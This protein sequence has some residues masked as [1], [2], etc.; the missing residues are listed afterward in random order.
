VVVF[1]TGVHM[2]LKSWLGEKMVSTN[3][4]GAAG[5]EKRT[6][7]AAHARTAGAEAA[8]PLC[9]GDRA[10]PGAWATPLS[11][12]DPSATLGHIATPTPKVGVEASMPNPNVGWTCPHPIT[13]VNII[14]CVINIIIFFL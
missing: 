1:F 2:A 7:D 10:P 13:C 11:K 8:Q 6:P 9:R 14:M 3:F 5:H 4:G 12:A